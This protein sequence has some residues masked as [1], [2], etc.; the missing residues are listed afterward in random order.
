M[1]E[2]ALSGLDGVQ[3]YDQLNREVCQQKGELRVAGGCQRVFR[4]DGEMQLND[5][6]WRRALSIDTGTSGNTV[7]WHPGKRPLLGVSWNEVMGFVCVESTSGAAHNQTLA[8]GEQA[9]L[10]LQA[11]ARLVSA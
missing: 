8:P 1:A 7:V 11:R 4:H 3:G 5:H 6:A 9:H 2:A 10:S